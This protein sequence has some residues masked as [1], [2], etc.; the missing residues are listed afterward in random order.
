MNSDHQRPPKA[1]TH[2]RRAMPSNYTLNSPSLPL[3]KVIHVDTRGAV[4]LSEESPEV[5]NLLALWWCPAHIGTDKGQSRNIP[6]EP[7]RASVAYCGGREPSVSVVSP[8]ELIAV[9]FSQIGGS[10][11]KVVYFTRSPDPDPPSSPSTAATYGSSSPST[12]STPRSLSP[13]NDT[14][15]SPSGSSHVKLSGAL[16]PLVLDAQ[17]HDLSILDSN[18]LLRDSMLRRTS[19]HFQAGPSISSGSR[20]TTSTNA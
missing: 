5:R 10:L 8:T 11:A 18:G 16:T 2:R 15:S 9:F 19:Q 14:S 3:A 12:I 17:N 13:S 4:I 6:S 1:I 20:R 7:H